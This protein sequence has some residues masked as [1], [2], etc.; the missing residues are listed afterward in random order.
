MKQ[1]VLLDCTH[2]MY[3]CLYSLL[4]LPMCVY[5]CIYIYIVSLTNYVIT[6]SC[7][8]SHAPT[9]RW[10]ELINETETET[11]DTASN[12]VSKFLKSEND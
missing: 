11:Q 1:S 10:F 6:N 8:V 5:M 7:I 4:I 2:L 12:S 3:L 9:S